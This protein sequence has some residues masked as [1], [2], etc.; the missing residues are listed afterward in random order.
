MSSMSTEFCGTYRNKNSPI[1]LPE[2]DA[3]ISMGG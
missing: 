1:F 2:P 3:T